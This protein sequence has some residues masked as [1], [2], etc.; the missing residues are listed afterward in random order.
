M[1]LYHNILLI[2]LSAFIL[3]ACG[4]DH[5]L[6][7][8]TFYFKE[9]NTA[10]LPPDSSGDNFIMIDNNN[11]S[12]SFVMLGENCEFDQTWGGFLGINT[13]TTNTEYHYKNYSS[14]F[15]YSHSI[16]LRAGWSPFG[17]E[18]NISLGQMSFR[19]D[20]DEEVISDL[21]T[22]FGYKSMSYTEDGYEVESV[23][24][25][26]TVEI[27]ETYTTK[28]KQYDNVLFFDLKD[29]INDWESLTI[30]KIYVAKNIGLIKFELN[31]GISYERKP[32]A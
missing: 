21:N 10:W 9:E 17:D 13:L 12:Q 11:I 32:K 4:P 7:E 5:G 3:F 2:V 15:G 6:K 18:I 1:K 8:E 14:S 23:P 30:T 29:F 25:K 31:N 22:N 26:S 19:Y 24:I 16:S 20:I 28:H 27:L